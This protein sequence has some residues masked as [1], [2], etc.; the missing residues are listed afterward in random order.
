MKTQVVI[1]T[2]VCLIGPFAVS[3]QAGV[4]TAVG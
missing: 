3:T 2:F 4:V 1:V